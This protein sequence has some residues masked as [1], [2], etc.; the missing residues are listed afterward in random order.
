MK[1]HFFVSFRSKLQS[2]S[3]RVDD[4]KGTAE[5]MFYELLMSHVQRF[6]CNQKE[7]KECFS[8]PKMKRF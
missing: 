2:Y 3:E 6:W 5:Q 1:N 8:V 4:P 7:F